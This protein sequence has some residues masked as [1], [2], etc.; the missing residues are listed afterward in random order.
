[1]ERRGPL[2]DSYPAAVALVV[3]ALVP[4]LLLTSAVLP[5]APLISKSLHLS[6]AALDI[7]T[8]LSDAGY[9]V[10]TVLAVQF[11]V[12]LPARRMLLGYVT[13][14]L[15]AAVLAAW[16]PDG[17]VFIGAFIA[18]GLCTS[19]MLIAAVPPLVTGW[20][21]RKMPWT[22]VIMNLC[23]FGAVAIGPVIGELQA[24]TGSWRPLFWG[25]AA[26][27]AVALLFVLLTYEDQPPQ[28]R[29]APWDFVALALAVCGCTAAFYGAARLQ[30]GSPPGASSLGPLLAGVVMIAALV[31]HQYRARHPLMPVRQLATTFPATG[32]LIA[33]CASASAVALMDLT[34][35]AL[36][37]A[38]P[39]HVALLFL[40]EFGAAVLTAALFGALFRTRF[41]PVLAMSGLGMLTAAAAV[42]TAL[43]TGASG[44]VAAG[45]AL[46]GLGVGA[47]VSPALFLA[48][49]SLRSAQIQRVFALIELL[50]GV[51]AFLVAPILLYLATVIGSSMTAGLHAAIWI[52][53]GI[54]AAGGVAAVA[55]YTLGGSRLPTP[56]LD[57]W[58][59]GEPAWESPPLLARLR[60]PPAPTPD[61]AR[62]RARSP[63]RQ[64]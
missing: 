54:A 46:I 14:F 48:G 3:C 60:R 24:S 30:G 20:P 59:S 33:M 7:T 23:I 18:E 6:T 45:S 38:S 39:V 15:A 35:T 53:L 56:D 58:T 2:A 41:T 5:L 50:R 8:G 49:F 17:A 63:E 25:V 43:A 16:A 4:F 26:V 28:D 55:L 62:D 64:H 12:H 10:G 1:M 13:A 32:I 11:A 40:P 19:L 9:A 22:A 34:L 57:A 21:V 37:N 42:L 27:A 52:C 29:S 51:T 47:S 36:R 31:V 61:A 44:V